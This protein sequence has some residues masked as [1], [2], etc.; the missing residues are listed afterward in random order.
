MQMKIDTFLNSKVKRTLFIL[1][2]F[3]LLYL[4]SYIIDPYAT[5]WDS[6]F[7]RDTVNILTEWV[8]SFLFC[9]SVSESSLFISKRL[10]T[11]IS[12]TQEPSKRF[13]VELILNLFAILIINVAIYVPCIY[14]FAEDATAIF[15]AELS[16]EE[17][18]GIIQSI[19]INVL[20]AFMIMGFH[21]ANQLILNWKNEAIRA[22]ELSR[23]AMDAELQSLK[24]QI[25]P[26]FVFNNLSV[27]SEL[28]LED[29][30][31]GYEYAENFSKIYRYMLVNAKK[32]TISL[33]EE[34][35]FLNSYIFLI[36]QRVGEG[37]D[38]EIEVDAENRYLNMP[39]LTLQLLVENALKH[40]K[41]IK[42]NPLKIMIYNN[43]KQELIVENLLLPIERKFDS[44]G[45]GIE[46]IIRRY[47][48]L[49]E[50]APQIE[51]DEK[52]FRVIVPLIKL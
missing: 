24:L 28:I 17:M 23:I 19:V 27:L 37:V 10:D 16:I 35:N 1:S 20:I 11:K 31:L 15:G 29:Q 7:Q 30:Q 2:A 13:F 5:F 3:L 40:N 33:D 21:I 41:T 38:F 43:D 36:K 39:P 32:N 52:Y 34:L 42:S 18:R 51:K 48:L 26:H 4:L 9:F 49:S 6:Y 50:K 8:I 47:N 22:S 46:N 44:S 25:D 12:W 14:F 45:L